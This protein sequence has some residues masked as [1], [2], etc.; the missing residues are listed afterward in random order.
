MAAEYA[1]AVDTFLN[2]PTMIRIVGSPEK[3]QTKGLLAETHRI[4]EPRK[5]IQIL[6]PREDPK[7]IAALGYQIRNPDR[8]HL[9]RNSV[10]GAHYGAETDWIGGTE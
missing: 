8:L 9:R 7:E 10:H 4:Y 2:E 6:D 5:I 1:M 3:P